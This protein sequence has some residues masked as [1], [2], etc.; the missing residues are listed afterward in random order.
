MGL[1]DMD[2]IS[3]KRGVEADGAQNG[4][5]HGRRRGQ[6]VEAGPTTARR[7]TMNP[8]NQAD[9]RTASINGG[10]WAPPAVEKKGQR[11]EGGEIK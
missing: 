2:G 3:L 7:R 5:D 1:L 11:N 10:S 6:S 4:G 9:A 8:T